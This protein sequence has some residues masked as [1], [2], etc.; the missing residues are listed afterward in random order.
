VIDSLPILIDRDTQSP[1]YFLSSANFRTADFFEKADLKYV[2]IIPA[3]FEGRMGKDKTYRTGE[4]KQFLLV[5]HNQLI[6]VF[7]GFDIPGGVFVVLK[8]FLRI[9]SLRPF[10]GR[11]IAFVYVTHLYIFIPDF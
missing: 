11:K 6:G 2:G 10:I 4:T 1:T 9:G 7:I 5:L 8:F 3:F